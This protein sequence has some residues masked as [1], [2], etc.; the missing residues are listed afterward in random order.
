MVD[1]IHDESND[2][3]LSSWDLLEII[4]SSMEPAGAV[5]T[6]PDDNSEAGFLGPAIERTRSPKTISYRDG[7]KTNHVHYPH[8]THRTNESQPLI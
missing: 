3:S 5:G 1:H 2:G 8:Q 6:A 4:K 7:R